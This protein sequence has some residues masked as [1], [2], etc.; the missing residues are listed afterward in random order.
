MKNPVALLLTSF[1]LFTSVAC[2]KS[3]QSSSVASKPHAKGEV[4][5]VVMIINDATYVH[6][7]DA[8]TEVY[9]KPLEGMAA[10]EPYFKLNHCNEGG[11]TDYFKLN[12]NLSFIYQQDLKDKLTPLV[13]SKFINQL[14]EKL[15]N[16]ESYV[17]LKDLFASPQRVAIILGANEQEIKA[18]L[19]KNKEDILKNAL[20]AERKTTIEIVARDPKASDAFYNEM[21][22]NYDY[23]IR[24]PANFKR[25]VRSDEF[26]GI[27]RIFGEKQSRIYMYDEAYTGEE[28]FTSE[29]IISKRN[30][31]LKD[32]VHG[33]DRP[34]SIP[35]Y[36]S[37]DVVNVD[38]FSRE[39]T[40]NG[41][42]AVETRGWW[43]MANDFKAGP[44]VCYTIYCPA[45]NKVVTI[46]GNVFAPSK[47]KQP[48]L[49]VIELA[50]TTFE[51]KDD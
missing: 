6:C 13:G 41:Y 4:G 43:E 32:H 24:T 2:E 42:R 20:S 19:L 7:L 36:M 17:V 44:F 27:N 49:R 21:M 16:G 45:I 10:E 11:F 28:Q 23:A 14:D 30:A 9:Q 26:N 39:T 1:I 51:T 38:V 3:S 37:T 15:A 34:D 12:Y 29:Y 35:T 22:K 8:I 48:L 5:K 46:E 40:L 33:A 50:A 31:I 25:S 47:K 18:N